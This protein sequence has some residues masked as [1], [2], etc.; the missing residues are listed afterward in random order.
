M[1]KYISVRLNLFVFGSDSVH[2][3]KFAVHDL[4]SGRRDIL[5]CC[6]AACYTTTLLIV[7]RP[8]VERIYRRS[9]ITL[10]ICLFCSAH[11]VLFSCLF[12]PSILQTDRQTF[13]HFSAHIPTRAALTRTIELCADDKLL[14]WRNKQAQRFL[15]VCLTSTLDCDQLGV[16]M[17][18][19]NYGLVAAY[20]YIQWEWLI[21]WFLLW[22]CSKKSFVFGP[23]VK[24]VWRFRLW[25][26]VSRQCDG[27]PIAP[28]GGCSHASIWR[29]V[30]V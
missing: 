2:V 7:K 5:T 23:V 20:S 8:R 9:R 21:W 12:P 26:C 30:F 19:T 10:L 18:Q 1:L 16:L 17:D 28:V 22:T 6:W 14:P 11:R 15:F 13:T 29:L 3:Q 25:T 4:C 27:C 24:T